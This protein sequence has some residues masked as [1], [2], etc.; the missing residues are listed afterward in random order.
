MRSISLYLGLCLN[1]IVFANIFAPN[2][3][4]KIG[5]LT[6]NSAIH[7]SKIYPYI[8]SWEN[9]HFCQKVVKIISETFKM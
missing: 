5:E 3:G 9:C 7:A 4:E 8:A 6:Q 2:I 1:F